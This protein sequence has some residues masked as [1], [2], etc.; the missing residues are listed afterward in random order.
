MPFD[1]AVG[2]PDAG[3]PPQV[4]GFSQG[5]AQMLADSDAMYCAIAGGSGLYR[6]T[7]AGDSTVTATLLASD[8]LG[9]MAL[10]DTYVYWADDLSVGTI[11]RVPKAGGATEIV[12]RDPNPTAI[13]VD[14]KAIYWADAQGNI[15]RLAK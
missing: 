6:L 15:M 3:I 5:C 8:I 9:P 1:L 4:P 2:V 10:D 7:T 12:A 14:A 11:Q 13:T